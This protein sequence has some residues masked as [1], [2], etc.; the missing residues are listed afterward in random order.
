M[1]R[2]KE[3]WERA[4]LPH[5]RNEDMGRE[6]ERRDGREVHGCHKPLI[7]REAGTT[8]EERVLLERVGREEVKDLDTKEHVFHVGR[9]GTK[10]QSAKVSTKSRARKRMEREVRR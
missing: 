5:R 1:R 7:G 8:R 9:L 6:V 2:V 4:M 3:E 10:R